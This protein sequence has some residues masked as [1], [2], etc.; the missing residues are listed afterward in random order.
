MPSTDRD[1]FHRWRHLTT[2]PASGAFNMAL[3]ELLMAVAIAQDAWVLRVYGWS[4]PTLSFGKNQTAKGSYSPERLRERGVD[5]VRRPTGGRA[6]LHHRELTYSVAAPLA[7]AG[8]L[9]DSYGAINQVLLTALQHLGVPAALS[10]TGPRGIPPGIIP[11]FDHP[12]VGEITVGAGKLVG[13]A[14]WR[15]A[16]ALLQHGSIL[17][18]DDQGQVN[19]FLFESVEAPAMPPAAATL[20]DVLRHPPSIDDLASALVGVISTECDDTASLPAQAIEQPA[21][22]PIIERFESNDWTW[23]R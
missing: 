6:I 20:R 13:S 11:C 9:R 5:V 21:L 16:D 18:D 15:S 8:T 17:I 3:D 19:D 2:P 23:R 1:A 22:A 10:G 12:S 4:V 14:Q 7:R